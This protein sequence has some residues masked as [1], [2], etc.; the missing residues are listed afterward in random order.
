MLQYYWLIGSITKVN[1]FVLVNAVHLE[2]AW[3]YKFKDTVDGNFYVTTCNKMAVKMMV[4]RRFMKYYHD[5]DLKFAALALPYE[6]NIVFK[7]VPTN[8]ICYKYTIIYFFF[9][10][11]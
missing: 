4:L 9:L 7:P 5:A 2:S 8:S 6:V 3:E 10:I 11:E 1:N